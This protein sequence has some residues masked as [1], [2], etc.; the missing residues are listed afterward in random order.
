MMDSLY[1]GLGTASVILAFFGGIA[2]MLH[3]FNFITVHKHYYNDK[4]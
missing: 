1:T 4:H 2:L 3:G